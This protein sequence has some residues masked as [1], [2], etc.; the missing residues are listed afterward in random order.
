MKKIKNIICGIFAICLIISFATAYAADKPIAMQN[1]L[2]PVIRMLSADEPSESDIVASGYCGAEGDGTNLMWKVTSDGTLT[3]SGTGKMMDYSSSGASISPWFNWYSYTIKIMIENGVEN[4]GD[5]AFFGFHNISNIDIPQSVKEIGHQSF[6]RCANLQNVNI[7]GS[8]TKIGH[9]AFMQ[10]EKLESIN[11]PKSVSE[12]GRNPFACTQ[13]LYINV[14]PDNPKFS[15][16]DGVLF[17]KDKSILLSYAKD[18]IE[19]TYTIPDTVKT[20]EFEAFSFCH[21]LKS[22]K[23]PS[24]VTNIRSYAFRACWSL[25]NIEI[26]NGLEYI[27]SSAFDNCSSLT[28]IEIP[29]SIKKMNLLCFSGNTPLKNIYVDRAEGL[30]ENGYFGDKITVT[31]MRKVNIAPIQDQNYTAYPME[32]DLVV[33]ED[34]IDG[35]ASNVLS[36]A[37]YNISYKN[38]VNAGEA[39]VHLTLV[40]DNSKFVETTF[41]ILPK[42]AERLRISG[43]PNQTFTGLQIKPPITVIDT[44]R[45]Y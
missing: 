38:N 42:S 7:P 45:S 25:E 39:V 37:L 21:S 27:E 30:I 40:P 20:I 13:N 11:I 31:Y 17:N 18:S 19:P 5:C 33:T 35:S 10:C 16:V 14:S 4:I 43:I 44:E 8:V 15:A 1:S 34:R 41:N 28:E 23:I 9:W 22:V 3:I 12:I 29:N 24:S 6:D 32:P 26:S 2:E 36:N